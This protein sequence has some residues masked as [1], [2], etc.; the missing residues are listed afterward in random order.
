MAD[1]PQ[2]FTEIRFVVPGP[3]TAWGRAGSRIVTAKGTGRQFVSHYT[4]AKTRKEEGVVR[5][6]SSWA[7]GDIPPYDGPVAMTLTFLMPIPASFT[8][9]ARREALNGWRFPNVKPDY[10]NLAKLIADGMNGI[11]FQDD[12]QIVTAFITKR[13]AEQPA[14]RVSVKALHVG[15]PVVRT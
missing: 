3:P 14:V 8:K 4:P 11:V 9:K 6:L 13:Y 5:Y 2:A 1:E 7:M 10:D 12:K 15:E